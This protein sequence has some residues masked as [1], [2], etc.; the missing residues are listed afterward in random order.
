[1]LDLGAVNVAV[2]GTLTPDQLAYQAADS[3]ATVAVVENAEQAAEVLEIRARCPELRHCL[4]VEGT[5]DHGVRPLAELWASPD[6][7]AVDRFWG[8]SAGLDEN[9]LVTI[10]YTSGTTG[11][12][13]GVML[14][15]RNIVTNVRESMERIATAAD[16][17][18]PSSAAVPHDRAPGRLQ[19]HGLGMS[20]AYCS[21]YHVGEL[22]APSGRPSS[23][24]RRGAREGPRHHPAGVSGAGAAACAVPVGGAV[25]G[26][27]AAG[28]SPASRWWRSPGDTV[29][30]RLA[31][32]KVRGA[33]GGRLQG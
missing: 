9:G 19:L 17:Y 20:R 10:V 30:D 29:A 3:G 11:E 15:H 25:G 16:D 12:P 4:Q 5:T 23:P 1:V 6:G 14:S 2:Y 31:L 27:V 8:R 32:A 33:F 7:A 21:V 28:R 13:K 26:E 22:L 24:A 18:G